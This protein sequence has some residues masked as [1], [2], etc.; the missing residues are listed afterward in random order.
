MVSYNFLGLLLSGALKA[1]HV[2]E[3]YDLKGNLSP[4]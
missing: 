1:M 2:T 4:V 3:V